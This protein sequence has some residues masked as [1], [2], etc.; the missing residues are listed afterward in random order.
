MCFSLQPEPLLTNFR[1]A[2]DVGFGVVLMS[3]LGCVFWIVFY[4]VL[5]GLGVGFGVMLGYS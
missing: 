2:L 1:I 3:I 4:S 5:N